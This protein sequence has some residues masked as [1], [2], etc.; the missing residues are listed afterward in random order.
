MGNS[1]GGFKEYM[2]LTRRDALNQGGFIWDFVDQSLRKRLDDGTEIYAYG[3]DYNAYDASDNNFCDNGLI[4]PDRVPN[5]HMAEVAHQYQSIWATL[6]DPSKAIVEIRN[7]NFFT[8][9]SNYRLQWTMLADG[10]PVESGSVA[11]PAV[12][13]Q[14]TALVELPCAMPAADGK[15]HILN[16]EFITLREANLVKAG[17]TQARV[18]LPLSSYSFTE[19]ALAK[20]DSPVTVTDNNYNRLIVSSP[21]MRVEFD[22]TCLL[23]TSDA[24]DD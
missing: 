22:R 2:D 8:D 10:R 19:P 4:S 3:G 7:E 6:P 13:P 1:G 16:L 17:H 15:E 14:Q 5:P 11:L 23:Y 21:A 18:E 20:A 12:A 24:A 9:L